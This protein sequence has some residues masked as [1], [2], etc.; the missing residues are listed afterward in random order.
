MKYIVL[1]LLLIGLHNSYANV[2][3][4]NLAKDKSKVG[5]EIEQFGLGL[6]EGN[7]NNY[8][9]LFQLENKDL[10]NLQATINIKSLKTG[11]KTRDRHL[12]KKEFFHSKKF[13]HIIF[14]SNKRSSIKDSY[15]EGVLTI[16]GVQVAVQ[17]PVTYNIQ[18]NE[19]NTIIIAESKGF[20][21]E[22]ADF[23]MKSYKHLINNI[24]DSKI[25]VT[26][27]LK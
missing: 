18:M 19:N 17:L 1:I 11:N 21:V 14:S 8:E 24:V 3:N 2:T 25:S 22:R 5:F 6:V 7:F 16:K 4:F 13:P 12:Q 10:I 9:I 15:L 20:K 26:F 23:N 27:E